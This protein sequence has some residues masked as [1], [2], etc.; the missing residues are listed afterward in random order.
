MKELDESFAARR[1]D[2][3]HTSIHTIPGE[4]EEEV[5]QWKI[6]QKS[7]YS[8][9]RKQWSR[10][11][12][13]ARFPDGK[14]TAEG[15]VANNGQMQRVFNAKGYEV[16]RRHYR[17]AQAQPSTFDIYSVDISE[18]DSEGYLRKY[19]YLEEHKVGFVATF[20][21][22]RLEDGSKELIQTVEQDILRQQYMHP[23][24]LTGTKFTID[25]ADI[26]LVR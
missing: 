4:T 25:F 8:R 1:S 23:G 10:D 18:Y 16:S 19:T 13:I 6:Q 5:L 3:T 2:L 14:W 12:L 22:K 20:Y 11:E 17:N 26:P 9:P 24:K 7:E 21:Y 15:F